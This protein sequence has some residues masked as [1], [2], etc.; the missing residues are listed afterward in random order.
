M[1]SEEIK[2]ETASACERSIFPLRNALLVNSPGSAGSQPNN[3]RFSIK[4]CVII[5]LP[6]HEI[7]TT[8]SPV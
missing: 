5:V 3:N 7:S 8:S 1:F 4:F 6:W 2:F